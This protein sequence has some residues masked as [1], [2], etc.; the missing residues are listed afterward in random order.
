MTSVINSSDYEELADFSEN[1]GSRESGPFVNVFICGQPRPGQTVGTMSAIY[2]A[3]WDEQNDSKYAIQNGTDVF[4]IPMVIKKVRSLYVDKGGRDVLKWFSWSPDGDK[5]YPEGAKIS[6]VIGG[7]LMT[8]DY[9]TIPDKLDESHGVFVYFNC[10]GIKCGAAFN[11]LNDLNKHAE[12]LEPLS[13]D[14]EFE[15][16]VV[17]PRRFIIKTVVGTA[18]SDF[19]QKYVF[20]FEVHKRL[21]TKT[22][23]S[24]MDKCK[25]WSA[26]FKKQ[27]DFSSSVS[28]GAS[29]TSTPAPTEDSGV[30]F[31]DESAPAD[32]TNGLGEIPDDELDIGI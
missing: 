16:K 25:K 3:L 20:N 8:S 7:I 27:F 9:K 11:L 14:P 22:V 12:T 30:T 4:F 6:V 28:S 2:P 32:E 18:D 13:D 17:L 15:K 5:D 19:G 29:A 10:K 23:Q 24:I 26:E 21:P 1:S 31:E